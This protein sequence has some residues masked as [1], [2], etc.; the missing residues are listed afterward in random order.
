MYLKLYLWFL[1]V[2]FLSVLYL[3]SKKENNYKNV[4]GYKYLLDR[5][6]SFMRRQPNTVGGGSRTN[7][8]GL[9]FEGRT[10]LLESFNNHPDFNVDGNQVFKNNK[11]ILQT[12]LFI[13]LAL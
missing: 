2:C 7:K 3:P 11:L 1:Y 13:A 12:V 6:L 9:S 5:K 10:D 8:N 4:S